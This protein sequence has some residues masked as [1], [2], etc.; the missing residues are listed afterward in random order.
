M[1]KPD[2]SPRG[3]GRQGTRGSKPAAWAGTH[4]S[5]LI[6]AAVASCDRFCG[7]RGLLASSIRST[8]NA[9]KLASLHKQLIEGRSLDHNPGKIEK[10][11]GVCGLTFDFYDCGKNRYL[12]NL[13]L[14]SQ[15]DATLGR[16]HHQLGRAPLGVSFNHAFRRSAP[17]TTA[18]VTCASV[19]NRKYGFMVLCQKGRLLMKTTIE[20]SDDLYRRAKAEAA[21]QGRKLKD[22][23]AKDCGW[24][25]K[26]HGKS[27]AV[28]AWPL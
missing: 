25:S 26:R 6:G 11:R 9:R 8:C 4:Q 5:S 10:S 2:W 15:A 14:A 21:L 20:V 27:P 3:F 28:G 23:V 16:A 12:Q 17:L 1:K 22:L 19:L 7:S 18:G 24:C 13:H